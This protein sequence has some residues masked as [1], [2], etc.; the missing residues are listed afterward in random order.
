MAREITSKHAGKV[1]SLGEIRFYECPLT[2]I[3]VETFELIRV[4]Y[5]LE[6][7]AQL[8]FDGGWADQPHWLVEAYEIYK[9]ETF[10]YLKGRKN[11]E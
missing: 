4:V 6:S 3:T 7:S 5:L 11:G 9:M 2:A 8:F 1:F 10:E